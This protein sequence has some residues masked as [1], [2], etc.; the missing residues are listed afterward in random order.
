[1]NLCQACLSQGQA[2]A[3]CDPNAN[4]TNCN[5]N[6]MSMYTPPSNCASQFQALTQCYAGAGDAGM[7][8]DSGMGGDDS[9]T[10]EADSGSA[11]ADSGTTAQDS[12]TG[13]ATD[14]A[15]E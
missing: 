11:A 13:T 1:V 5:A 8:V 6:G 12:G 9:S 10:T 15:P 3:S 2:L 14:A 7:T 4:K